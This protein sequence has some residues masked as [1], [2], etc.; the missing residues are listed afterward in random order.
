LGHVLA[1]V[2]GTYDRHEYHAEKKRAFEALA[3]QI[4]RIVNPKDNVVPLRDARL[5]DADQGQPTHDKVPNRQNNSAAVI[6]AEAADIA[7]PGKSV[8]Q[9]QSKRGTG[10]RRIM[11]SG[12]LGR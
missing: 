7:R 11:K 2:R 1:G 10:K 8:A 4:D 3:A 9:Q 5:P 6:D 12:L